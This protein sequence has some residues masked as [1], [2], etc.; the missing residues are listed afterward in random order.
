MRPIKYELGAYA[1]GA[2]AA[3]AAAQA[4]TAGTPMTLVGGS[5]FVN[6]VPRTVLLTFVG[7][8]TGNRFSIRGSG[9]KGNEIYDTVDGTVTTGE[10]RAI[11]ASVVSI[12]PEADGAGNVSA[13]TV[14][15]VPSP[16][17]TLD[18]FVLDFRVGLRLSV[19]TVVAVPTVEVSQVQLGYNDAIPERGV[20]HGSVFDI[21]LPIDP[22]V[23]V[24]DIS[25]EFAPAIA[26]GVDSRLE[27]TQPETVVRFLS[28]E[29][30]TGAE[31]LRMDI[32]QGTRSAGIA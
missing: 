7:D 2:A 18:S 6:D 3:I 23:D 24:D 4:V 14:T 32:L 9:P 27:L 21:K 8:E 30:L 20:H 1:A 5:P 13:G 26:S 15:V 28:N 25:S 31:I 17:F 11:F 12:T 16:W 29:I 19:P 22:A 10:S